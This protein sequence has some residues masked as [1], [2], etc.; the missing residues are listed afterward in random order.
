MTS[1][2]GLK[3]WR[4]RVSVDLQEG[5]GKCESQRRK[6]KGGVFES[7]QGYRREGRGKVKLNCTINKKINCWRVQCAM[8]G[9]AHDVEAEVRQIHQLTCVPTGTDII[10]CTTCEC[11]CSTSSP[12]VSMMEYPLRRV[13]AA[14]SRTSFEK[15]ALNRRVCLGRLTAPTGTGTG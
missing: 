9:V 6:G 3:S 7:T 10:S 8:H 2:D 12:T 11:V 14:T 4:E 13:T 15:V 5:G 1:S